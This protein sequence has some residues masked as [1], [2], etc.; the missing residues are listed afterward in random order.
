[1]MV[2]Q[3][4]E[5]ILEVLD[6]AVRVMTTSLLD[7]H[8]EASAPVHRSVREQAACDLLERL[9]RLRAALT[10]Y[11]AALED[12]VAERIEEEYSYF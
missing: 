9:H 12:E 5:P 7:R 6:C 4:P 1:M 11:Q 2:P 3:H 10:R 8:G